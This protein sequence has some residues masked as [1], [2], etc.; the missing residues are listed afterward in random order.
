MRFIVILL[1]CL[2][3]LGCQ[4]PMNIRELSPTTQT[5]SLT[6]AEE[7]TFQ[8]TGRFNTKYP[9]KLSEG[10]YLPKHESE[11][12]IFYLGPEQAVKAVTDELT[13]VADGGV[14]IPHNDT[15]TARI[16]YYSHSAKRYVDGKLI[17][18][19]MDYI[20]MD[21]AG[22]ISVEWEVPKETVLKFK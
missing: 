14:F 21:L 7:T 22:D 2:T 15:E 17:M 5:N 10:T 6:L 9:I 16:G 8:F 3:L 1:T 18:N 20:A 4:S 19:N 13:M 12:G 11:K